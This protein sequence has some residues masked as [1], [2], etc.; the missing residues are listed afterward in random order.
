MKISERQKAW[1]AWIILVGFSIVFWLW[2]SS[3]DSNRKEY[4][5][6]N[7][8]GWFYFKTRDQP[9]IKYDSKYGFIKDLRSGRI[10]LNEMM[11]A[12]REKSGSNVCYVSI[13]PLLTSARVFSAIV[14]SGK[15]EVDINDLERKLQFC[16][17]L[18]DNV[19]F[20]FEQLIRQGYYCSSFP[21]VG[22]D[23]H[24]VMIELNKLLDQ[25]NS[26][27]HKK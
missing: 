5:R 17:T 25:I 2:C 20:R 10:S 9:L 12:F 21:F 27:I 13:G 1:L 15:G 14:E 19:E 16:E 26:E 7:E 4:E 3:N 11:V 18:S 23:S 8:L 24:F 22:S 6:K